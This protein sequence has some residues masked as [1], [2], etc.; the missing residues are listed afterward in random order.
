MTE[1]DREILRYICKGYT[2]SEIAEKTCFSIQCIKAH[3]SNIL[4]EHNS[5]NRVNLAYLAGINH[6]FK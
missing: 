1:L 6:C 3:I 2:N 4:K 5:K